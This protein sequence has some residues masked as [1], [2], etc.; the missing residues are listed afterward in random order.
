MSEEKKKSDIGIDYEHID[1]ADIMNQIKKKIA[2]R[3]KK[4]LQE[5]FLAYSP[6]QQA[7]EHEL[8]ERIPG[9][10][11]KIKSLLLKFMRP[12][13]P[14]IK[15]L[16]L[17]VH[18]EVMETNRNLHKME[19]RIDRRLKA[20]EEDLGKAMEYTKLLH[21]LSHN[22]VVELSKLKIEEDRLMIETRIL[23]KDF[24]FLSKREKALEKE[25]FK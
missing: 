1:V 14:V 9:I 25:V 5:E 22:I 6:Q 19:M 17:P 15:A 8:Q 18:E 7:I 20:I 13:S 10:R 21:T 12:F 11:G 3:P 23:E 16:V 24:E 2:E 4:Q